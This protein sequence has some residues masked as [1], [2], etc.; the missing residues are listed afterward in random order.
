MSA[1]DFKVALNAPDNEASHKQ[2]YQIVAKGPID[3]VDI[4]KTA[5]ASLRAFCDSKSSLVRRR[6]IGLAL[7]KIIESSPDAVKHLKRIASELPRLGEIILSPTEQEETRIVA[8]LIVRSGLAQNIRFLSFWPNDNVQ[9]NASS[10]PKDIGPEWM[11]YFQDFLDSL[12]DLLIVN[13][14]K[15]SFVTYAI[16]LS[17]SD[18]YKWIGESATKPV[19]LIH[20]QLLSIL[21]P[22]PAL[23]NIGFVDIPL[24]HIEKVR[25]R[26]SAL[27]DSQGREA[28]VEPW[29]LIIDFTPR[30]WTYRYNSGERR[31]NQ[32]TLMFGNNSDAL[33]CESVVKELLPEWASMR[34]ASSDMV[35][36]SL[37]P[38]NERPR[39][40]ESDDGVRVNRGSSDMEGIEER[41]PELSRMESL[42]GENNAH[43]DL[44]PPSSQTKATVRSPPTKRKMHGSEATGPEVSSSS[45]P[46]GSLQHQ[47][48]KKSRDTAVGAETPVIA[49]QTQVARRKPGALPVIKKRAAH[50]M[51]SQP[52]P[53]DVHDEGLQFPA[54][55]PTRIQRNLARKKKIPPAMRD[56]NTNTSQRRTM[57][58][59]PNQNGPKA[60]GK[61]QEVHDS[62]DEEDPISSQPLPQPTAPK[63]SKAPTASQR[64]PLET[65]TMQGS[66]SSAAPK[67]SGLP[68][69]SRLADALASIPQPQGRDVFAVPP[70]DD[71]RPRTRAKRKATKSVAYREGETSGEESSGSEY[72]ESKSRRTT[73]PTKRVKPSKALKS[74]KVAI[75]AKP[76]SGNRQR[77]S[78]DGTQP[79]PLKSSLLS[80]LLTTSQPN[81][82]VDSKTM[83]A[84][85]RQI[86]GLNDIISQAH[87]ESK[88]DAPSDAAFGSEIH[89][90]NQL[91]GE[92][93]ETRPSIVVEQQ[94]EERPSI[95]PKKRRPSS[96]P[97]TTPPH[98]KRARKNHT[99]ESGQHPLTIAPPRVLEEPSSP[100]GR[101][102]QLSSE[103][104]K[105]PSR[106]MEAPAKPVIDQPAQVVPWMTRQ[107]SAVDRM[108]LPDRRQTPIQQYANRNYPGSSASLEILSSN[109]KP[110]PASPHAES[111][112]ISGHADRVR[113]NMEKEIGEYEIG[114]SDPF[115][116][117]PK[118]QKITS[119]TRRLTA[120]LTASPEIIPPGASQ[121]RPIEIYD[122]GSSS[123]IHSEAEQADEA[124]KHS[125]TSVDRRQ[126]RIANNDSVK[127][128][129]PVNVTRD[130]SH[131][132]APEAQKSINSLRTPQHGVAVMEESVHN[133]P[134][135]F[136]ED[137]QT[138]HAKFRA[139]DAEMEG[140]TLV[141][142]DEELPNYEGYPVNF[143]SSPPPF[144]DSPSSHSS[145]S[146]EEEPRTDA[147]IPTSEAEEMQWEKSLQPHQRNLHEQL[148]R[149]SKRV[150]RHIV[151]SETAVD[152]IAETY[153]TDGE[154]SLQILADRHTAE[155]KTIFK[156]VEQKKSKMKTKSTH[157]LAR[158]A[159]GR[160]EVKDAMASET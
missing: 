50:S 131:N 107:Q 83:K 89:I 51:N 99:L 72:A 58:T 64:N 106:G 146:A 125:H 103:R 31:A 144:G 101:H 159:K 78:D 114:K 77:K 27:H 151:D 140:D 59:K 7:S 55:S 46:S 113:V 82:K 52:P 53:S 121:D 24:H 132:R 15:D 44:A 118:S 136:V 35:D 154:R 71:A 142:Q 104:S 130:R 70:E 32:F 95:L 45:R 93:N 105:K 85:P 61:M 9:I 20:R 157:L 145:T 5:E 11:H 127:V 6:W 86:S 68:K 54:Q 17:A 67:S 81:Q 65:V 10:F 34:V 79:L 76:K 29:D 60:K 158:L 138:Q 94:L 147:A 108:H 23:Q 41:V 62:E 28:N 3:S 37:P 117:N 160:Q 92:Q 98:L 123:S 48:Q 26:R 112:A 119:F 152:D 13:P 4:P 40:Q 88:D 126:A 156:D 111:T 12:G 115:S 2:L 141:E 36:F 8:A 73:S 80:N 149:V 134:Q 124:A 148:L 133:N 155:F 150:T 66:S 129:K 137:P 38:R 1:Q 84:P 110:T 91:N 139:Q 135:Q 57:A 100:C 49:V 102:N 14:K 43:P 69:V 25:T 75:H 74:K 143:G 120:K 87:E 116:R 18:G 90:L 96:P 128:N 56:V 30:A 21:T 63:R 39:N 19:V 109:S 47:P 97:P 42:D 153:A 33:E 122:A 22:D 16:F